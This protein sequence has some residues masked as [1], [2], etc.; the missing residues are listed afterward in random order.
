MVWSDLSLGMIKVWLH[1][2]EQRLSVKISTALS[3]TV[4]IDSLGID[5]P[6]APRVY[7]TY[8]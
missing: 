8:E 7:M 6:A 2:L 4:G 1:P 3:L 5:Y